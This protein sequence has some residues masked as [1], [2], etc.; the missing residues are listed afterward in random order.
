MISLA[1]YLEYSRWHRLS[2]T[3]SITG[4]ILASLGIYIL[5]CI[6]WLV[7]TF[8]ALWRTLRSRSIVIEASIQVQLVWCLSW[9]MDWEIGYLAPG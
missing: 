5:G 9:Y 3:P 2:S 7:T 1:V 6:L 4:A 8:R